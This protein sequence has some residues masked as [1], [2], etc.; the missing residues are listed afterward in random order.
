[1]RDQGM[2]QRKRFLVP[3]HH[4][5]ALPEKHASP[6]HGLTCA[7][8]Q[9]MP[10]ALQNNQLLA[11]GGYGAGFEVHVTA[12]PPFTGSNPGAGNTTRCV[13]FGGSQASRHRCQPYWP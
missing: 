5:A 11:Y 8:K 3:L 10:P 7:D 6:V 2:P 13:F 1:M 4:G 9:S 12:T